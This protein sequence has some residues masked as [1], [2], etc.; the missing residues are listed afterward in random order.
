MWGAQLPRRHAAPGLGTGFCGCQPQLSANCLPLPPLFL[1]R[2]FRSRSGD[3]APWRGGGWNSP[4]SSSPLHPHPTLPLP[5][6]AQSP[7]P[8]PQ[9]SR[10]RQQM[11]SSPA[12]KHP[13]GHRRAEAVGSRAACSRGSGRVTRQEERGRSLGCQAGGW[14][15]GGEGGHHEPLIRPEDRGGMQLGQI[16]QGIRIPIGAPR[17]NASPLATA[18][19]AGA[20]LPARAG[21]AAWICLHSSQQP[22]ARGGIWPRRAGSLF[23]FICFFSATH[24]PKSER[25]HQSLRWCAASRPRREGSKLRQDRMAL[26]G[27]VQAPGCPREQ[28]PIGAPV[29]LASRPSR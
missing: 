5:P 13:S 28:T 1:K 21:P 2:P 16:H 10:G 20:L 6:P 18:R 22:G 4:R 17:P 19:G 12:K 7:L 27:A 8:G 15:P 11:R 29:C 23:L 25:F 14:R 24:V 26:L 9:P 3:S